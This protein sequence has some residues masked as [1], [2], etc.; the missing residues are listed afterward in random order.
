MV[1]YFY[2]NYFKSIYHKIIYYL[3]KLFYFPKINNLKFIIS[4]KETTLNLL[5]IYLYFFKIQY[6]YLFERN[7]QLIKSNLSNYYFSNYFTE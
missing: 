7:I 5:Y 3:K 1:I 2:K 4:H 6:L